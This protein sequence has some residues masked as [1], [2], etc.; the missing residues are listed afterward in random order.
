VAVK[1]HQNKLTLMVF[2]LRV[3]DILWER[4]ISLANHNSV[5]LQVAR[6]PSF[7]TLVT[8]SIKATNYQLALS[9]T[10]H[11]QHHTH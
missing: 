1:T 4:S 6:A 11:R 7:D 2:L 8:Y 3:T 9:N 5:D 10:Q